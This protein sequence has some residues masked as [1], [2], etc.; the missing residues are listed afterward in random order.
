MPHALSRDGLRIHFE[1][2]GSGTPV[3]LL[4]PNHATCKSW[5]DLG[6]FDALASSGFRAVALDARGYGDS[7]D[8]TVA[9]H[10]RPGTSTEDIR[11]VLDL[12]DLDAVHVCGFSL[13]AAAAVR[14]AFD[15]PERAKSLVLGGLGLGPLV[16]MGLFLGPSAD[17]ARRQALTQLDRVR[18]SSER[19]ARYFILAREVIESVPLARVSGAHLRAPILGIAGSVDPLSPTLLYEQLRALGASIKVQEVPGTGHGAC[20]S[21]VR[22]REATLDFLAASVA[23]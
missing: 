13:G 19:T 11:A 22:F 7:E 17:D 4:H 23:V 10:L 9:Q 5:I 8:A 16:Q 15:V 18:P 6:W 3:L 12:L 2:S 20:F 1:A 14:F 21:D